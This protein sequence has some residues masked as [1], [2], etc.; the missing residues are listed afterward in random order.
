MSISINYESARAP[1]QNVHT[2][3]PIQSL[4][5][6]PKIWRASFL[7]KKHARDKTIQTVIPTGFATLDQHLQGGWPRG[8]LT[9]LYYGAP[10]IGELSLILPALAHL[11][12]RSTKPIAWIQPT[13]AEI[14]RISLPPLRPNPHA[15]ASQGIPL[16][17]LLW[18]TPKNLIDAL[19][20]A[21]QCLNST[22]CSATVLWLTAAQRTA[23]P[24]GYYRALQKLQLAAQK[25]QDLGLVLCAGHP[26]I[27]KLG[28]GPAPL[29]IHL[30]PTQNKLHVHILKRPQGW[31]VPPFPITLP[32]H[33]SLSQHYWHWQH[34]DWPTENSP[35][36]AH[37][38][39]HTSPLKMRKAINS[40]AIHTI[41]QATSTLRELGSGV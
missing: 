36:N 7:A 1:H 28:H 31:S 18:I 15:L 27:Q 30:Q 6:H 26:N 24:T 39:V 13:D 19:W 5:E 4:L 2:P 38:S 37:T 8:Q 34:L 22:S 40:S 16:Q 20:A 17:Q 41:P 29:R 11:C 33:R 10:G 35:K 32:Q 14:S 9:E 21:E 12:A 23:L 3:T 25:T